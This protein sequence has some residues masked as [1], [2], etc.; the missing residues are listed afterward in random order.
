MDK[1]T[2]LTK[3]ATAELRHYYY[4]ML[5]MRRFE[6]RTHEMYVKAKI[7]GY[8]HLNL[9]EEATIVGLM[10]ALKPEDYIFTNYREH[11]YILARGVAPGPLMAELFGRETGVSGGRGGSMHLFDVAKGFMGGYAIVGGQIP[12]AVGAAYALRYQG[13]PGVVVAQ[14]GDAST[15]IGAFYESLNLAKLWRCPVIF[16]IANNGYGMGST[17][18]D[19]SSEPDLW[20]KG[21]SFRVHGEQVDGTDVLAVRDA[22]R[23]LRE[24]AETEGEPVIL[25]VVSFRFRGHSVIDADRYRDADE[26][27]KGRETQDPLRHYSAWLQAHELAD[28]AW[29]KAMVE[30]V[31]QEMQAAVDFANAGPHPKIEDIYTYMYASPV[32]NIPAPETARR[33]LD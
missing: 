30:Q 13:K 10:A 12:L 15:N 3:E 24:R 31:E 7:G 20:K 29:L 16:F 27:R 8:C 26:V 25:D 23:R 21:A 22:V 11:G 9:G 5:L 1:P 33:L 19:S 32:P 6:E 28:E 2:T 18:E 4:Q 17:I 14:M